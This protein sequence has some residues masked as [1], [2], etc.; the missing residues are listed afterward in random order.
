MLSS[1]EYIAFE[2]SSHVEHEGYINLQSGMTRLEML[3]KIV[4]SQR[5][6][7]STPKKGELLLFKILTGFGDAAGK[8]L[9]V[10]IKHLRPLE[11][12]ENAD[13]SQIDIDQKGEDV[14][15]VF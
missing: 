15:F 4:T 3:S 9:N 10:V 5:Y 2:I 6:V 8:Q 14:E 13:L 1:E 12:E 11:I 7:L